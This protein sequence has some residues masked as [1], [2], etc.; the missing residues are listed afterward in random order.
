MDPAA[1]EPITALKTKGAE[2]IRRVI[3]SRQPVLI[4][5]N[6]RTTAVLQDV[7]SFREQRETLLLL[8]LL[9]EGTQELRAKQGVSHSV[10]KKRVEKKLRGLKRG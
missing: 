10:A 5:Q 7:D 2:L 8:K 1:V 6:G 9:A 3:E 4:T